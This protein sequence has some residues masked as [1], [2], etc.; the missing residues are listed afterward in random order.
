MSRR[1]PDAAALRTLIER[2]R[3]GTLP[4][5]RFVAALARWGLGAPMASLLL[6]DAGIAQPASAFAYKPTKRGGGGTLRLLE[7]QAP[8]LLNPHFATGLKDATGCRVF[9]DSLIIWD[10]EGN[11]VPQLAAELPSR[12]NGGLSADGRIVTWK[13][14]PG[15]KWHDG[16]PFTADDVIFNWQFAIDPAAAAVTAG[17]YRG[18]KMEKVDALTLRVIFDKPS[19]F[20][21]GLYADTMLVAKHLFAPFMGAKSREAPAN[22]KPVGTGPYRFVEFR[23]ADLLKAELNPGYH[24]PAKPFFDHLEM[25]G[26]GDAASAA[27]A[28]LQTGEYDFASSLVMED[29]VL[30]RLEAGGKGRVVFTSGSATTAVYLN[31]SD[32]AQTLDGERSNPRTRHPVFADPAVR[33]AMALL[34]DRAGIQS[35]L[36]G[37]QAMATAN[38]LNNPARYRSGNTSIEFSVEKAKATLDAAGWKAGADG[39][40]QKDG[41]RLSFLFQGGVGG[42]TQKLQSAIKG[43]AEKAG[44]QLEL[45]AIPSAVFFS[46]DAGNPDTYGKF[47]ADIQVYNWTNTNP[48]PQGMMLSFVS[49]E[50]STRANQW[51]GVNMVRWQNAEYDAAYRAAETET[52]AVKRAALFIRMNDLVVRDGYVIPVVARQTTRALSTKLQ[53]PFSPWNNDLAQLADWYRA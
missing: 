50:A 14:K 17:N 44:V 16:Q 21:P 51:L 26:G 6:L 5:R 20:W 43:S 9:H 3:G 47:Q 38:W 2:V 23:P 53:A 30:K 15:V 7:W 4:R 32:P 34:V 8:T 25:K 10:A 41:R 1:P 18:L 19:P 13:L 45:K 31:F 27:R 33:R 37:R 35:F 49:W 52:D 42:V 36:Y 12:A 40:R 11:P 48:D 29:D 46:S 24:Q 22:L 28:V 39:V